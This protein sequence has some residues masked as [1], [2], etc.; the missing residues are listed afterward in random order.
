MRHCGS[1]PSMLCRNGAH[2]STQ[3]ARSAPCWNG[4]NWPEKNSS[5][6]SFLRSL[7]NHSGSPLF[8]VAHHGDELLLFTHKDLVHAH[9]PQRRLAPHLSP[10]RQIAL[11]D[12]PHSARRQAKMPR[13]T[14]GRR[15]LASFPYRFVKALP[16]WRLARQK[17]DYFHLHSAVR[18]THSIEFDHHRGPVLRPRQVPHF[19]LIAGSDRTHQVAHNLSTP[20][21]CCPACAAP[22]ASAACPPR[23]SHAGN[24]VPRPS[25][26]SRPVAVPNRPENSLNWP[27]RRKPEITQPYTLLRR[28]D[29]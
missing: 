25:R 26:Y 7:P 12:G 4:L 3:V 22:I 8:Q 16:E 27:T 21:A 2:M 11:I 9:L 15:A 5:R 13:H 23:R 18:T 14:T 20:D 28:A 17:W 10:T 29:L 6:V 19:P 1:H 24:L